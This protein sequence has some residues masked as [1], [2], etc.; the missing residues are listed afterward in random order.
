MSKIRYKLTPRWEP[1]SHI[2]AV[3]MTTSGSWIESDFSNG[4]FF[5]RNNAAPSLFDFVLKCEPCIVGY[6]HYIRSYHIL[7]K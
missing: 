7:G 2:T 6:S 3:I 1:K 4:A 5:A